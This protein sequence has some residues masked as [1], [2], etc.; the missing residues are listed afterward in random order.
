MDAS[1]DEIRPDDSED[2]FFD[3]PHE[4]RYIPHGQWSDTGEL[5]DDDEEGSV[6]DE[7]EEDDEESDEPEVRPKRV[8]LN[9]KNTL[10]IRKIPVF[11]LS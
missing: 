8:K 4:R 6:S 9:L 10:L 3:A 1:G 7:D 2:D 5:R 11:L